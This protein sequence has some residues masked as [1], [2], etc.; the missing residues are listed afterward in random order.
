LF[1]TGLSISLDDIVRDIVSGIRAGL[2]EAAAA[3]R[4]QQEFSFDAIIQSALPQ[5]TWKIAEVLSRHMSLF[6]NNENDG[7][8]NTSPD[9]PEEPQ[10]D[11]DTRQNQPEETPN[12]PPTSSPMEG[13]TATET[14]TDLDQEQ[15]QPE[16]QTEKRKVE[17]SAQAAADPKPG[18]AGPSQP[19]SGQK[20]PNPVGLGG[21]LKRRKVNS[22]SS[23]E[24]TDNIPKDAPAMRTSE[25][26]P[27]QPQ[28]PQGTN[29]SNSRSSGGMQSMLNQVLQSSSMRNLLGGQDDSRNTPSLDLGSLLNTAGPMISQMLSG[30]QQQQ[31]SQPGQQNVVDADDIIESEISDPQEQQRWKDALNRVDNAT[32]PQDRQEGLSEAYVSTIPARREGGILESILGDG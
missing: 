5:I 27:S 6:S 3:L 22:T 20:G 25:Q 19:P 10:A 7:T 13:L 15:D 28:A 8:A 23:K 16:E 30:G 14:A 12:E 9:Q 29:R 4:E 11:A 26:Q 24:K 32:A 21:G 31:R 17:E 2:L 1:C 18:A